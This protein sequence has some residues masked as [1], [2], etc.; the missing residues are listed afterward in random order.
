MKEKPTAMYIHIPFCKQICSYCDFCKMEYHPKVV[1][2]YL[3]QLKQEFLATYHHES[4][5][6]LYIGGG[7]PSVLS[8]NELSLLFSFLDT[9]SLQ[10]KYE[11]TFECN[12]ESITK[13]LLSF[14][15]QHRVN[16]LSIG[17]QT[18]NPQQLQFLN[19]FH[20]KEMVVEKMA[21]IRS[22]GFQNV[23]IDLM[24]AFP[25]QTISINFFCILSC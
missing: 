6:T 7:T 21:W 25:S 3:E 23:N 18:I 11:F 14:L 10:P 2:P 24:Y 16:R 1:L 13:E 19:R 20:T 17:I 9:I 8:L 12:I 15:K 22:I 5:R 4:L